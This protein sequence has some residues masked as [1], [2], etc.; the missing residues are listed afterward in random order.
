[1]VRPDLRRPSMMNAVG[2]CVVALFQ[3][4]EASTFLF[5]DDFFVSLVIAT[6]ASDGSPAAGSGVVLPFSVATATISIRITK[7]ACVEGR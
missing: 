1:M 2:V 4:G 5:L 3:G 7:L 6:G